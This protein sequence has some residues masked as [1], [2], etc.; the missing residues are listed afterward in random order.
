MPN[1]R[2]ERDLSSLLAIGALAAVSATMCL[3]APSFAGTQTT[4]LAPKDSRTNVASPDPSHHATL[5]HLCGSVDSSASRTSRAARTFS[6]SAMSMKY[7][8]IATPAQI[9]LL[10]SDSADLRLLAHQPTGQTMPTVREKLEMALY[11]DAP[12]SHIIAAGGDQ[13]V[14]IAKLDKLISNLQAISLGGFADSLDELIN[15]QKTIKKQTGKL[16]K[17]TLGES[18]SDLSSQQKEHLQNNEQQERNFKKEVQKAA[19]ELQKAANTAK[20]E[21]DFDRAQMYQKASDILKNADIGSMINQAAND[22]HHNQL[23]PAQNQQE[24]VIKALEQAHSLLQSTSNDSMNSDLYQKMMEAEK[25]AQEEQGLLSQTQQQDQQNQNSPMNGLESKQSQIGAEI[26]NNGFQ[27]AHGPAEN[28]QQELGQGQGKAAEG[29]EQQTIDALNAEAKGLLAM[30]GGN[31][32]G[33]G[34][35]RIAKDVYMSQPP[36]SHTGRLMQLQYGA[37]WGKRNGR[38]WQGVQL[39]HAE[40]KVIQT[41]NAQQFPARYRAALEAYYMN[42]ANSNATNGSDNGN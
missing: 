23:A 29:S 24:K 7:N 11:G 5:R 25:L 4:S 22:I 30:M 42:L 19:S 35:T 16:F 8:R 36:K 39:T 26:E 10:S 37:V 40:K 9:K 3:S 6:D 28:A 32:P 2:N 14:V 17:A 33:K 13:K 34:E 18:K 21:S 12:T 20:N 27:S 41:V 38:D 1:M 31:V 15:K